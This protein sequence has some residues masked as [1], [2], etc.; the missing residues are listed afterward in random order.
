MSNETEESQDDEPIFELAQPECMG[1][2]ADEVLIFD[3]QAF[4]EKYECDAVMFTNNQL[5]VLNAE[6]RKWI[7]VEP[8][9]KARSLKPVKE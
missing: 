4:A 5:F 1:L 2:G 8:P 7:P 3:W 9:T 6:S